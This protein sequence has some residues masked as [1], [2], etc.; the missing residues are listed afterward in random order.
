MTVLTE[1]RPLCGA[2]AY[3]LLRQGGS[4]GI[5][6]AYSGAVYLSLSD[7][8]LM[9]FDRRRGSVPFGIG[10]SDYARLRPLFAEGTEVSLLAGE[11]EGGA[12]TARILTPS[13][14]LC[15]REV[16][17]DARRSQKAVLPAPERV[18]EA[19]SLLAASSGGGFS[20]AVLP[21]LGKKPDPAFLSS[22]PYLAL[23]LPRISAFFDALFCGEDGAALSAAAGKL[24]GLGQGLTP[25]GDDL[26]CGVLY[27]LNTVAPAEAAFADAAR[28]LRE[29]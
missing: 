14:E 23:A 25:S 28:R 22:R 18:R 4:G 6:G 15:L 13:G 19:A 12:L 1:E 21:L 9:L 24:I 5:A 7:G 27:C 10:V 20:P 3:E 11:G 29:A 17:P 16:L 8:L 26:F 2:R